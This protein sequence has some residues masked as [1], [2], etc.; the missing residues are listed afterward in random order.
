VDSGI[1]HT[2]YSYVA[3][4]INNYLTFL[5]SGYQE[6]QTLILRKEASRSSVLRNLS[7]PNKDEGSY[8]FKN[9]EIHIVK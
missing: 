1:E 7:A 3:K 2:S 4:H 8:K 5:G 6:L 9:F